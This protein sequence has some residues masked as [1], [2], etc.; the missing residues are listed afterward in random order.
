M[1]SAP[2]ERSRRGARATVDPRHPNVPGLGQDRSIVEF[3]LA[4]LWECVTD[5]VGERTALVAGPTR[6]TYAALEERANRLAHGL[7][8]LGVRAGVHVGLLLRNCSEHVEALL[9]CYKLRAVPANL[10]YRYTAAEL[11]SVIADGDMVG[12]ITSPS[13]AP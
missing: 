1:C 5:A 7:A 9:A 3:N 8:G 6:L 2:W 13:L 4:D 11:A 10:N 12:V